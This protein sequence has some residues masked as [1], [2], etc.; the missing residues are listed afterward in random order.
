MSESVLVV[1]GLSTDSVK[2]LRSHGHSVE[3]ADDGYRAIELVERVHPAALLMHTD[4]SGPPGPELI[5]RL[6]Q[7]D[8]SCRTILVAPR[9][10]P[11]R[12]SELVAA[13]AD[14]VLVGSPALPFL[15]WALARVATGGLVLDP[16][17]AR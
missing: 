2:G 12:D 15:E 9:A 10:Q 7:I 17:V 11:Q 8:P 5:A 6:S 4:V 14:G 1:C 13:G 16:E 3:T